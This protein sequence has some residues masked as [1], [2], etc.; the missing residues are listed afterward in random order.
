MLN[1]MPEKVYVF[2]ESKVDI[3]R[4]LACGE[5]ITGLE[6]NY[7]NPDG[8]ITHHILNDMETECIVAIFSEHQGE[9]PVPK[10]WGTYLPESRE[11]S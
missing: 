2:G 4:R 6:Y 7:F 10:V 11:I 3:N 9:T 1:N 8:Y 5:E